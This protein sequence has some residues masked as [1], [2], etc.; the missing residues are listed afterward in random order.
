MN[1]KEHYHNRLVSADEAV[2]HI[3]SG[4]RVLLE[5][6]IAY[7]Q[8]L[9]D[10]MVR[11]K[12][13][14]RG[15]E[16]TQMFGMTPKE[17]YLEPGMEKHFSLVTGMLGPTSREA[18]WNGRNVDFLATHYGRLPDVYRYHKPLDVALIQ[19]T[20]PDDNGYVSLGVCVTYTKPAAESAKMVIAIVND[21]MPFTYGDTLLHVSQI[22]YFVEHSSPLVDFVQ[23]KINDVSRRIGENAAELIEDRSCLQLG[24][25]SIPDA[26]LASLGD[27]KDLGIFAE[28][29]SD[30]VL[31]LY[32]KG[33]VTCK[34]T[35]LHPGKICAGLLLGSK[36]LYDWTH[37]N[38]VVE[39]YPIDYMNDPVN[40]AKNDKMVSIN[41]CAAVDMYGQVAAEWI[42]GKQ[43]T[44]TGGQ[45]D[46]IRGAYASKGGKALLCMPSTTKNDTISKIVCEHPAGTVI[47]TGRTDVDYIV[48]EYGHAA[49]RGKTD[50]E[51]ARALINIAHPNF[52]EQLTE[53]YERKHNITL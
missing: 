6:T 9:V 46:Y 37:R 1:W 21:Q 42:N 49:L 17:E 32:E 4:S 5:D 3:K 22:D 45:V 26:V 40:I 8:V 33:V 23:G 30:G 41:G 43:Y 13:Q 25:G 39:F 2:S 52:R 27:K 51:R 7:P 10:A 20:P 38:P 12:D 29:F 50:R 19:V 44:G 48:T 53:E 18:F 14:Y 36:R 24:M 35:G 15:V 28:L 34:Y 47:T 11:N 31:D 16:F